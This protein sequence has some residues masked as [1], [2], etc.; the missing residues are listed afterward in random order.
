LPE[1]QFLL[2]E[3]G[4]LYT[5]RHLGRG[6]V[7][8]AAGRIVTTGEVDGDRLAACGE[9]MERIDATGC[10]VLPGLL[11]PHEH[12]IGGSGERG[13]ESQTPEIFLH[14]LVEGGITTVVGCLGVDTSTRTMQALLGKA[15]GLRA[16]GLSAFVYT[17]GYTVPP[18]TITGSPHDDI[19]FIDEVIGI[20][21][22]AISDRR[23]SRPS[24]PELARIAGQAY[25]GGMLA[26]KAGVLHFHVG[27]DERR[28]TDVRALLDEYGI[29]AESLYPTHVER[30]PELF[31]EALQLTHRG[32]TVDI[33]VMEEDLPKWVRRYREHGGAPGKLTAS[34]DAAI[35]SPS[36]LLDQL[37]ECVLGFGMPLEEVLPYVTAN[38][39]AALKLG[40]KG[41][42]AE[43]CDADV[44]V[45][46]AGSLTLRDVIAG[47][48]ILMRNGAVLVQEEFLKS[49]KRRFHL[50]ASSKT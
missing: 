15:K 6:S 31:D 45:V 13:F 23:S 39:A 42:L 38:T 22:T 3:N 40:S 33:D 11:D 48:R 46:D 21:E 17:G 16:Q 9:W 20:G 30:T 2:V 18:V 37:R 19:L 25:T 14:E 8:A 47:G 12:L 10:A 44:L 4:E 27:E 28:L 29:P 34:S 5:P 35:V 32:V 50:N 43:G 24:L 1:P 7:F 49:S 36:I 41:R 26:G